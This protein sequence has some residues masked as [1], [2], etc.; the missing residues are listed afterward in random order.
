[1]SAP[2]IPRSARAGAGHPGARGLDFPPRTRVRHRLSPPRR[3]RSP[4]HAAPPESGAPLKRDDRAAEVAARSPE[5]ASSAGYFTSIVT[6]SSMSGSL[7]AP[8]WEPAAS[9]FFSTSMPSATSP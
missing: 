7:V 4:R 3:R 5:P 6:F 2:G 1:M 8:L 9:S